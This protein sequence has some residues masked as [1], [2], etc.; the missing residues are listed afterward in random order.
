VRHSVFLLNRLPTK[1]LGNK[2][3]HEVWTGR[4]PSL[5]HVRVFG[6]TAHAKPLVPHLKKLDDRS[7]PMVYFGVEEGSNCWEYALEVIIEM[8]ILPCIHDILCVH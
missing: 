5:G 3:P 7:K 8:I 6:C 2:T 4:K 1:I